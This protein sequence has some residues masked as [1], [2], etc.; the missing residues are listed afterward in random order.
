[1]NDNNNIANIKAV[2]T[3]LEELANDFVFIGGATVSLYRDRPASEVRPTDDVDIVIELANYDGYANI[4]E[5]LRSK[6]F[7]NDT[8]SGVICRYLVNGITVDVMPTNDGILGFSNQWYTDGFK[9]AIE[10][11]L[12]ENTII[13]ILSAPYFIAAKL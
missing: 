4:E 5:Q 3:A 10:L 2:Y 7:V 11:T 1:M 12:D 8:A 13:K 9:N 6:G